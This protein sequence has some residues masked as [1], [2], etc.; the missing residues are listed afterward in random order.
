MLSNK[1]TIFSFKP[2][3]RCYIF[4]RD[5]LWKHASKTR[6]GVSNSLLSQLIKG[7]QMIPSVNNS[8]M[9]N[10]VFRLSKNAFLG[11]TGYLSKKS[12]SYEL[13]LCA[14]FLVRLNIKHFNKFSA[15]NILGKL[16]LI[17]LREIQ[18]T[19]FGEKSRMI[20]QIPNQSARKQSNYENFQPILFWAR[21]LLELL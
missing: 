13:L 5:S 3:I 6:S 21:Q 18:N 16:L 20:F 11:L 19:I 14:T 9:F 4:L 7:F 12:V 1:V 17:L 10:Q 8:R 2:Y 15:L